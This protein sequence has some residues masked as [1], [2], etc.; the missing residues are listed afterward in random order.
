[1]ELIEER[2]LA[3][4]FENIS[5][6]LQSWLDALTVLEERN[7]IIT[8]LEERIERTLIQVQQEGEMPIYAFESLKKIGALWLNV[9]QLLSLRMDASNKRNIANH[10]LQLKELDQITEHMF[11]EIIIEL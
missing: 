6:A 4:V 8:C 10:L 3:K 1:M 9:V 5:V 7:Q 11:I 2:V